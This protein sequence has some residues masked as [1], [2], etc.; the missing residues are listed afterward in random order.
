M[1]KT[2]NN[3]VQ[4][5]IHPHLPHNQNL[6]L[7]NSQLQQRHLSNKETNQIHNM[8]HFRKALS[9]LLNKAIIKVNTHQCLLLTKDS[10]YSRVHRHLR[11]RHRSNNC[12]NI[13]WKCSKSII[14]GHL[15][16]KVYLLIK[17]HFLPILNLCNNYQ[18]LIF[19][20]YEIIIKGWFKL[21]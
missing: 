18:R 13:I 1:D 7:A 6:F 17:G 11:E 20:I 15:L 21:L 8:H 9:I 3:Q 16:I 19:Y 5:P 12:Y 4:E 2:S 14:K 10:V